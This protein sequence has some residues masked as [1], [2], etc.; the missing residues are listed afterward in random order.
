[1][2]RLE[3]ALGSVGLVFVGA[4][5]LLAVSALITLA[6]N[7]PAAL[8]VNQP[9]VVQAETSAPQET[10][11]A[12]MPEA[13]AAGSAEAAEV[14]ESSAPEPE[15]LAAADPNAAAETEDETGEAPEELAEAEEAEEPVEPEE[16]AAIP[17]TD[18]PEPTDEQ[19]AAIDV[20]VAALE[21]E[22]PG[23]DYQRAREHPIHFP[24]MIETASDAECLV[25]H[26]EII[27]HE[28]R[29]ASPAGLKAD[30]ALAWYQTLDTYIPKDGTGQATFHWR[31][32]G[33]PLAEQVMNLQCNFCHRGNDI[34]EESPDLMP[35]RVV[36]AANATT[37]EFTLRKMVNPA[38]TCLLCHGQMP[39]PEN[40]MTLPGPWPEIR[41][42]MEDQSDEDPTFA[43]G[44]LSCH[45][46]LF[47]T[48]RHNVTYL[49]AAGI[50]ELAQA[51]SDTCYGC[52]GGRA[53]YRISYPYPRHPWP[54]MDPEMPEWAAD[55]PTE[56]DPR[57]ARPVN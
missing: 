4:M 11:D 54:G 36:G 52:H 14:T 15:A 8:R 13:A 43:N 31:H 39:D 41:G 17:H 23:L 1:M 55:R 40:I 27:D 48:N 7:G 25:C 33:S 56:S 9:E 24:P 47:R 50:E 16:P 46:D 21:A 28:V 3:T 26:Q 37:P 30:E 29:D 12:A 35:L 34:R 19:I 18:P 2:K 45:Q 5:A 53:W 22:L 49:K 57:Y 32:I 51:G 38:E 20:R 6:T 10:V 42:D 44:C